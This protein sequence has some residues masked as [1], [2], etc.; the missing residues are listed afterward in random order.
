MNNPR[1]QAEPGYLPLFHTLRGG[2]AESIHYGAIAVVDPSGK[3]FA[4]YGDPQSVC[5]LRSSAKPL[6]AL[7]LIEKGGVEKFNMSG[8]EIAVCC[9]SHSSTDI[10][11]KTI[12]RLQKK[13]GF[14]EADLL[15]CTHQPLSQAVRAKLRDQGLAP[16]QNHHNCSGKHTGMLALGKLMGIPIRDYT[17]PEHPIQ[18]LIISTVAEMCGLDPSKIQLGRDGCS[19]PAFAMPLYNAALGWA[20]LLDPST[21]STSRK[22][23]CQLITRSIVKNPYLVAG[24]G[25][26]DTRLMNAAKG[27]LVS[28]SGAEAYQ[29]IGIFPDAIKLGSPA[30]GIVMKIADGDQGK[31]ARRAVMI[32][33]L[34]QLKVLSTEQ[35]KELAD[36]GP[37]VEIRN[38]CQIVTGEGKPCFQLQ[39]S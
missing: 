33:I 39:Y 21:L 6:Q 5:F 37:V 32:E 29:A 28:K 25:R 10:H 8:E 4:W 38:S 12:N 17:E 14:T 7:S 3:L 34:L 15:C 30:L 11:L 31:R 24:P 19:V 9:A 20:K 2:V 18:Q 27:K 16:T 22:A 13:I 23:A 26:F 1:Q 36:L 35:T